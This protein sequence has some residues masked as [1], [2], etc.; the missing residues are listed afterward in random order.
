MGW[1]LKEAKPAILNCRSDTKV[2]QKVKVTWTIQVIV[3]VK[4]RKENKKS[5]THERKNERKVWCQL[6]SR[7]WIS[8]SGL[9]VKDQAIT[10][11][12][13]PAR[14]SETTLGP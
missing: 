2:D 4:W 6:S 3:A 9:G 12:W 14:I 11:T 10:V 7:C 8:Q 1:F 5:V 13:H